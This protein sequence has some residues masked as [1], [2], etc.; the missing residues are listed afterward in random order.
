MRLTGEKRGGRG[1]WPRRL[2][3]RQD[4]QGERETDRRHKVGCGALAQAPVSKNAQEDSKGGG[5]GSDRWARVQVGSCTGASTEA[6]TV[7]K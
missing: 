5:R 6:R 4:H 3:R 2:G 1:R 7:E